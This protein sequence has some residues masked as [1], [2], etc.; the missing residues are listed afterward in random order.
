MQTDIEEQHSKKKKK[1][2]QETTLGSTRSTNEN[3]FPRSVQ[4]FATKFT[5]RPGQFPGWLTLSPAFS[6]QTNDR[7]RRKGEGRGGKKSETSIS[8]WISFEALLPLSSLPICPHKSG[9]RAA[10]KKCIDNTIRP[11]LPRPVFIQRLVKP[12]NL[13]RDFNISTS[14]RRLDKL[15]PVFPTLL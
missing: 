1:R 6:K 13:S 4:T 14:T 8:G 11:S 2:F 15:L 10:R 5:I 3:K 12:G 9:R 7:S